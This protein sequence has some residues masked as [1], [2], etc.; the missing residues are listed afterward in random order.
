MNGL[1]AALAAWIDDFRLDEAP[2][3][4]RAAARKALVNTV[5]TAIGAYTVADVQSTLAMARAEETTGPASV[6]VSGERM[7]A[8]LA[9]LVNGVMCNTL[10]QDET[11]LPTGTHPA[12]TT[13]PVLLTI[14][15]RHDRNGAQLL[16]A[17]LV[18]VEVTLALAGLELIDV[19]PYDPCESSSVYGTVGAAAAAAKLAGLTRDQTAHALALAANFAC[20]LS[21]CI[22]MGTGEFHVTVANASVNGHLA[23]ALARQG[24]TAAA[25]AFE[26]EGGFFQLFGQ[27]P[28][29]TLAANDVTASVL[30]GLG[31]D[32]PI[33]DLVYKPY[34][35]TVFNTALVDGARRLRSDHALDP[36]RIEAV[37]L[38]IG[39]VAA[40][41][42]GLGRPPYRD[43]QSV[44]VSSAFG[45]ACVLARGQMTLADT[46]DRAA[47]DVLALVDRTTIVADAAPMTARVTIRTPDGTLRFDH[48]GQGRDLR[49]TEAEVGAI[50]T[51]AAAPVLGA[52]RT[53]ALHE[54]LAAIEREPDVAA[55]V[56]ATV[57]E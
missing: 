30:A 36:A 55:L 5:G 26:G 42:G 9:L 51:A 28:R 53:R 14:G 24:T 25:T 50:F 15:E 37:E 27:V 6:L 43:R 21:E 4:V 2:P 47:A 13:L 35:T 31:R 57:A 8:P 41:Y 48:D 3:E 7:A 45:V 20:G 17:F 52:S 38:E 39:S 33:I 44:L 32:W 19:V 12:Q 54:R 1:A 11:H 18:G 23:V 40:A 29:A 46:E 22:K 49:L 34:P 10:L 56:R 16:E